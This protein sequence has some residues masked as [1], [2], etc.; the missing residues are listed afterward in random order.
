MFLGESVNLDLQL[1]FPLT[2][3]FNSDLKKKYQVLF[4][5]L[6]MCKMCEFRITQAWTG[7][8]SLK[9]VPN[10]NLRTTHFIVHKFKTFISNLMYYLNADVIQPHWSAF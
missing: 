6:L 2:I 5:L 7:L 3:V 1:K 9:H 8:M 10:S 4:K